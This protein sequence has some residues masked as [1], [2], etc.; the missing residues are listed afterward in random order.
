MFIKENINP[1]G[2]KCGD[3][4]IRAIAKAEQ[5]SWMEIF[6]ELTDIARKSY[7]VFND[8][9]VYSDYLKGYE[10]INVKYFNE[11][12]DKKRYTVNE[13]CNWKGTYIISIANHLTTVIDGNIYDIWDCSQKSTY[14]IWKIK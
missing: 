6:E 3:C 13:I 12:N 7:N 8:P 10:T 5:K 1:K 14:K 4:V 9:K 2:K 11:F